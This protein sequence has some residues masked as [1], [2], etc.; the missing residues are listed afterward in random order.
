M[1]A[2]LLQRFDYEL[3]PKQSWN[4]EESLTI[5]PVDGSRCFLTLRS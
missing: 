4:I 3:D 1:I 5:R 2:K